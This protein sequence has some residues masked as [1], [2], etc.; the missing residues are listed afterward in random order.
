MVRDFGLSGKIGPVSYSSPAADYPGLAAPR[1]YSE[2]TQWLIDQEVAAILAKAE[3]RAQ[4]P[5]RP[6]T[7]KPSTS[8]PPPCWSRKPSPA[9]RFRALAQAASPAALARRYPRGLSSCSRESPITLHRENRR[10]Y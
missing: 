9:T 8:S 1:S 10:F 5:A 6:A 4:E 3:T 7:R 2:H